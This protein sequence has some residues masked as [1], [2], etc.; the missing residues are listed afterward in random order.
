MTTEPCEGCGQA[1][2]IAGGVA[3]LWDRE[4]G[5]GGGMTLELDDGSERFLC[6][7]CLDALPE[8]T[9]I[10]DI[11]A[12]DSDRESEDPDQPGANREVDESDVS[13]AIPTGLTLGAIAGAVIGFLTGDVQS[14]AWVGA[15]IGVLVGL[16]WPTLRGH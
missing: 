5:H 1:V 2:H 10:A 11:E 8:S 7:D 13:A 9:T 15:A 4:A 16:S 6:F 12:L 3:N 14:V